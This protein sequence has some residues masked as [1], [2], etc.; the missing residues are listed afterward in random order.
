MKSKQIRTYTEEFKQQALA[1]VIS[2]GSVPMAAQK[3]GIPEVTLYAW[4]HK[5]ADL[6]QTN[7]PNG[8]RDFLEEIR[9][10]RAENKHLQ[11]ANEVLKQ[12][13]VFFVRTVP[14]KIRIGK[15]GSR[16]RCQSE[17]GLSNLRN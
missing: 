6:A 17:Y 8:Q 16:K 13:A 3:L 4:R 10:L 14:K 12:A 7:A 11:H 2:L 5:A 1:M 15:P 9:K